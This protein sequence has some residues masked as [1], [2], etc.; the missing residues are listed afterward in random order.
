M[1]NKNISSCCLCHGEGAMT[2]RH[3]ENKGLYTFICTCSY[4]QSSHW[5]GEKKLKN[6]FKSWGVPRWSDQS[7]KLY[8]IVK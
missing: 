8:E 1:D 4:A 2:A 3:K 6:D 7:Y 5:A